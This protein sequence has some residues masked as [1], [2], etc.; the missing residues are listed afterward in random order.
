MASEFE[1]ES[2][3][4]EAYPAPEAIPLTVEGFVIGGSYGAEEGVDWLPDAWTKAHASAMPTPRKGYVPE[5]DMP[6]DAPEAQ[7]R[8]KVTA[9]MLRPDFT[10]SKM[11]GGGNGGGVAKKP[12]PPKSMAAKRQLDDAEFV[13][14]R[15]QVS[16]VPRGVAEF[17]HN[18]AD[19][20]RAAIVRYVA[21]HIQRSALDPAY[22]PE[23][24]QPT[25][26]GKVCTLDI[27]SLSEAQVRIVRF[28]EG[29]ART[30][31]T[32]YAMEHDAVRV[33]ERNGDAI[34]MQ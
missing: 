11:G 3:G 27:Y 4:F 13:G 14:F 33:E 15:L 24:I 21:T 32:L 23:V 8:E 25:K 1:P 16:R 22:L 2:D 7:A 20:K 29:L 28:R 9:A 5:R 12:K 26:L 10:F 17:Y 31:L 18:R 6:L 30:A 19:L 34:V